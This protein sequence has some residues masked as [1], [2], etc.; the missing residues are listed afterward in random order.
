MNSKMV[1]SGIIVLIRKDNA[2]LA[3]ADIAMGWMLQF[4]TGA[5]L[6]ESERETDITWTRMRYS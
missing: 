2:D 5:V 1:K 3:D 6:S 4:I